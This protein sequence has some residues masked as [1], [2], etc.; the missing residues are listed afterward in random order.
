V[1]R[2]NVAVIGEFDE[3]FAPHA[4]T[5]AAIGHSAAALGV[6]AAVSWLDTRALERDLG[7]VTHA[8]ALWCAPGSPYRSLTGA[9]AALRFGRENA[10]PTLGTCGGCQH[11]ILEYARNV[12]GFKDAAHAEYDPYASRLFVT[13]LA[14][15]LAGKTMGVNVVPGSV[16]GRCYGTGRVQETYYCNFGLNPEQRGALEAG[17]LCITGVD[18]DDEPRIFELPGHPCYVATLFVPQTRSSAEEPHPLV[19]ALL[20]AATENEGPR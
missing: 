14:C 13:A 19:T 5:N 3:S 18:D 15:S 4:A 2:I 10:V 17:G 7:P 9:L 6:D 16:A 20:S 11:I 1:R 8:D 12:L